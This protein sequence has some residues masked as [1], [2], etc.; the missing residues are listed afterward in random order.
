MARQGSSRKKILCGEFSMKIVDGDGGLIPAWV[1][2][3]IILMPAVMIILD[4]YIRLG[5]Y[6]LYL[7]ITG[8]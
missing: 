7:L 5:M 6:E 1:I 2:L 3:L 4:K 8:G